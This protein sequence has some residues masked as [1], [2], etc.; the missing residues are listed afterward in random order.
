[1]LELQ[2]PCK[3]SLL[4]TRKDIAVALTLCSLLLNYDSQCFA[5]VPISHA[6]VTIGFER[7][8]FFVQE[9]AGFLWYHVHI[10]GWL[11]RVVVVNI[12]ATNGLA[13]RELMFFLA[14]VFCFDIMC[15]VFCSW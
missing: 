8:T 7:A 13:I 11:Q 6:A 1:M 4:C 12:E 3:G 2:F 9:S 10:W 15:T 5:L 14:I